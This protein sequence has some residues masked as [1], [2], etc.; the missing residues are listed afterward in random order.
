MEGDPIYSAQVIPVRKDYPTDLKVFMGYRITNS[1]KHQWCCPGGRV[2]PGESPEDAA[3]RELE[4]ETGGR[5]SV[6]QLQFLRETIVHNIGRVYVVKSYLL[7]ASRMNLVNS[8]PEEHSLM[9]WKKVKR[10]LMVDRQ[11]RQQNLI[12]HTVPDRLKETISLLDRNKNVPME[13]L[14]SEVRS[15]YSCL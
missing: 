1:F 13:T 3:I 15:G 14:A 4:E 10:V 11:Q 8:S 9:M 5:I 12:S 6:E 7:D 2:D